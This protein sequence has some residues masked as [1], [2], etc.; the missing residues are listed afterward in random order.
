MAT[1][2]D[3]STFQY[4]LPIL[5]FLFVLIISYFVIN[6]SKL[7]ENKFFEAILAIVIAVV[8][9]V[10]MGPRTYILTIVPGFAVLIV[11]LFLFMALTGF[12]GKDVFPTKVIAWTFLIIL[13]LIFVISALFVFSNYY[14]NYL[15]GNVGGD[16]GISTFLHW[17]YSPRVAGAL[18]VVGVGA[19]AVWILVKSK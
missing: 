7:I 1:Q 3:V 6:K 10:A 2:V 11:G 12:L 5:S 13:G 4:F 16:S 15:P 17:L 8:F 19:V 14:N 9:V 18:L